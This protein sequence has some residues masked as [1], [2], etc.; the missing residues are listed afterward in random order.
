MNNPENLRRFM[1]L[2]AR[3]DEAAREA[4]FKRLEELQSKARREAVSV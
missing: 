3:L 4:V 1:V 2:W